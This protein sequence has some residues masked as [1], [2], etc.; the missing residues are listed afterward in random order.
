MTQEQWSQIDAYL[1]KHLVA[2]D[3]ALEQA[4]HASSEAGLP[5]INVAPNQGKF[6]AL[7]AQIQGAE[8]IL[9]IGTLGGYSTIWLARTLPPNGRLITLELDPR[10]AEV[11][12][13]NLERA[14]VA[15]RVSI[16]VG[17]ALDTLPA[18]QR[19]GLPPFDFVFIDA[20]KQ[21]IPQYFEW[22]L[23]LTRRGSV[24]VVDNV[25]RKGAVI[26]EASPDPN[27]QGVRRLNELL[28]KTRGVSATAIQTVG[29]KGHDG[30]ALI[31]V[32]EEL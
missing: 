13:G 20:D 8:T 11:A 26:D 24:I 22:A 32:T 30:F 28:A 18:L 6:L 27:V 4:L 29:S 14:G 7:L 10:H 3:D 17:R 21:S 2:S 12:R 16:R 25:V 19:E 9:E 15:E 23:R 5:A 31:R 1:V